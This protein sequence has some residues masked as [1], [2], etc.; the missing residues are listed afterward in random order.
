MQKY[1]TSNMGNYITCTISCNYRIATTIYTVVYIIC[2]KYVIVNT[3]HT[4]GCGGD[5]DNDD[6]DT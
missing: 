6:N 5:G 1:R 4:G 2:F 3:L